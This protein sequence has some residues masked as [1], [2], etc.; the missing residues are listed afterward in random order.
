M[1]F[2]TKF[3]NYSSPKKYKTAKCVKINLKCRPPGAFIGCRPGYA[4]YIVTDDCFQALLPVYYT[5]L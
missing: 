4:I 2:K 1:D 3:L 5:S